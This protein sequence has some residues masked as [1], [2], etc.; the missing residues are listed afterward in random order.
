MLLCTVFVDVKKNVT[1]CGR[2]NKKKYELLVAFFYEPISQRFSNKKTLYSYSKHFFQCSSNNTTGI[3]VSVFLY[4][5]K[6]IISR[7]SNIT[8]SKEINIILKFGLYFGTYTFFSTFRTKNGKN[9]TLTWM[10]LLSNV[11]INKILRVPMYIY[12]VHF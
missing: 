9:K 2:N 12:I 4:S 11:E 1:P 3:Q 5:N 10:K 8:I 6:S 7:Y